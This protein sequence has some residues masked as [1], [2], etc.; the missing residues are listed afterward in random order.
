M[1]VE[2]NVTFVLNKL[3]RNNVLES[4]IVNGQEPEYHVATGDELLRELTR[5]IREEA[6]ELDPDKPTFM[7]E[8]MDIQAV[9]DA[10]LRV[11]KVAKAD[12]ERAVKA[13]NEERGDYSEAYY[14]GKLT[15]KADD[16]WV[17]YYRNEPE[18][19]PEVDT[20]SV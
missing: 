12:F 2:Q 20:H 5:K 7:Q 10:I 4:M 6:A 17:E 9:I 14:V 19:F 3:V 18:R 8:L 1:T 13:K 16:P 15:L 11:R